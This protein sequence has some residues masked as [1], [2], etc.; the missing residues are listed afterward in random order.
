MSVLALIRHGQA[1]PFEKD[2]D[3]LTEVGEQQARELGAYWV[4]RGVKWTQAW[5]GTLERQRRTAEIVAECYRAAGHAFPALQQS[6]AFNEYAIHIS[7]AALEAVQQAQ[8]AGRNRIFQ[9]LIE[10]AMFDFMMT[11]AF[12]EFHQRVTNGLQLLMDAAPSQS[13]IALFTSGGPIGV[14]MQ[15]VLKAPPPQAIEINWRVRNGSVTEFLFSGTKVSLD[16]FNTIP[17]LDDKH[18]QTFR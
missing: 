6:D 12:E 3:R 14:A 13:R 7:P 9:S 15:S 18:L 16:S 17:H 1:R 2:S 8:P 11:P 5:C 4:Q 10:Q